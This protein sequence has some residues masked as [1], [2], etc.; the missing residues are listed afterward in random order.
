MAYRSSRHRAAIFSTDYADPLP[1]L[2]TCPVASG[3]FKVRL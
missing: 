3:I 1:T 2:K